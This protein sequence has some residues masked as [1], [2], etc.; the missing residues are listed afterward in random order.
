MARGPLVGRRMPLIRQ[1][2]RFPL[3]RFGAKK[4]TVPTHHP[5]RRQIANRRVAV[6]P[7]VS[8]AVPVVAFGLVSRGVHRVISFPSR[9]FAF[10]QRPSGN[11][12]ESAAASHAAGL[13]G[14]GESCCANGQ[15]VQHYAMSSPLP[16][17]CNDYHIS[18]AEE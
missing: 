14:I 10:E 5:A 2:P 9:S 7:D 17:P 16:F 12:L 15:P 8:V 1:Q 13:A 6:S 4:P 11:L 3:G 18:F